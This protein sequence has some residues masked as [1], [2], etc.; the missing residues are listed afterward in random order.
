VAKIWD[1][2]TGKLITTL[3]HDIAV[4]IVFSLAW[5]SAGKKLITGSYGPI[6][7]FDTAT[8]KQTGTLEGHAY[9]YVN[10]ISL[11]RNNRL[12]ASTSDDNT[13]RIWN[14][15]TNLPVGPP[16]QHKRNVYSAAFSANGRVLVTG[17]EDKNAYTWD[18]DAILKKAGLEDL[19][20]IG[21]V[22]ASTSPTLGH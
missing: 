4:G 15:D 14:L 18:V 10:A 19:L 22:S 17:C 11:S 20:P 6:R 3:G 13:A 1:A 7:I 21:D 8:W 12:L 16:L 9:D 2:K 5:T